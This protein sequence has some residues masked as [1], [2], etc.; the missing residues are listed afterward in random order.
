M[1]YLWVTTDSAEIMARPDY[2]L[3]CPGWFFSRVTRAE[4]QQAYHEGRVKV[5]RH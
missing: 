4:L 3:I 2:F 5:R 1:T